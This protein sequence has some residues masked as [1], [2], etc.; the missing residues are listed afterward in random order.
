MPVVIGILPDPTITQATNAT[1]LKCAPDYNSG[2]GFTPTVPEGQTPVTCR[3]YLTVIG[4]GKFPSMATPLVVSLTNTN[5]PGPGG[6][7]AN[8]W[9]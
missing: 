8:T 7:S 4:W 2:E 6:G 1:H 3:G 9:F 5:P